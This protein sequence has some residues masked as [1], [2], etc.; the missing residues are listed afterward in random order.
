M[1]NRRKL[2][3]DAETDPEAA[4][5]LR[6]KRDRINA[7]TK[8]HWEDLVAQAETDPEA[9]ERLAEIRKK[10]VEATLRSRTKQ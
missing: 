7:W 8:N 1:K 2:I 5:K 4:E 6:A 9:A 10:R 3:A